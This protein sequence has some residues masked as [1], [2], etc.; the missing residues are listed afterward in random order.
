MKAR[1][2]PLVLS[3]ATVSLAA[4]GGGGGGG[5][6]PTAQAQ[7][8]SPLV[9]VAGAAAD[10]A[11]EVHTLAAGDLFATGN[12]AVV[13]G[14]WVP[15]QPGAAAFHIFEQQA[16]GSLRDVT[17]QAVPGGNSY[18]GSQHVL[19]GDFAG[20]GR[21]DI[22]FPGYDSGTAL[23]PVQSLLLVNQGDGT[24]TRQLLPEAIDAAGACAGD[25]NNDG[26]LDLLVSAG[27]GAPGGMYLNQGGGA[28]APLAAIPGLSAFDS[29]AIEPA[30]LGQSE[31]VLGDS[32][33]VPG[34]ESSI[35]VF[36]ASAVITSSAGIDTIDQTNGQPTNGLAMIDTVPFAVPGVASAEGFVNV[37]NPLPG[38]NFMPTKAVFQDT[39]GT[40]GWQYTSYL[41]GVQGLGAN[42]PYWQTF[43]AGGVPT[44][45]FGGSDGSTSMYQYSAATGQA[46]EYLPGFFQ[47][48]ASYAKQL[49]GA[50]E[51]GGAY[52]SAAGQAY[53]VALI[54]GTWYTQPMQ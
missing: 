6:S 40:L 30:G 32:K 19:I 50:E 3:L 23:H 12:Q 8:P 20:N 47:Q 33:L 46:T 35:S 34:Y 51:L 27:G 15:D 42:L 10:P 37:Y 54:A 22:L 43:Q 41:P 26:R 39:L 14:G 31:V 21:E 24:F 38:K 9:A 48:M 7:Q 17:A 44:L 13:V 25:L 16:D 2:L 11:G 36:S 53:G 45:L 18:G 52:T 1:L 49:P 28:F 4:C 5:S 29:C